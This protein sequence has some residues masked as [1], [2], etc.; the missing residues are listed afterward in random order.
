MYHN[1][2]MFNT[3]Q[4]WY[5]MCECMHA[6]IWMIVWPYVRWIPVFGSPSGDFCWNIILGIVS[7]DTCQSS[8]TVSRIVDSGWL[9]MCRLQISLTGAMNPDKEIWSSVQSVCSPFG[10]GSKPIWSQLKYLSFWTTLK[11]AAAPLA[12]HSLGCPTFDADNLTTPH[13]IPIGRGGSSSG[14]S[15]LSGRHKINT[16]Q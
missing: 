3:S 12:W 8:S 10:I 5:L 4:Y 9:K 7:V 15:T 11:V 14:W 2:C 6:Y 1:L 13:F 16:N